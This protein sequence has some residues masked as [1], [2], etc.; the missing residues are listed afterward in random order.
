MQKSDEA[1]SLISL[2]PSL[3]LSILGYKSKS[4][5]KLLKTIGKKFKMS[6]NTFAKYFEFTI[7]M[8]NGSL[9]YIW[10]SDVKQIK[11]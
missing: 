8:K 10:A 5:T 7:F 2:C 11:V 3:T 1:V 4:I 6:L 9:C